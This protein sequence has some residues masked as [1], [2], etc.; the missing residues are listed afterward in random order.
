MIMPSAVNK[1]VTTTDT[2]K[3][4]RILA[5]AKI[6]LY[7]SNVNP[8][9]HKNTLFAITNASSLSDFATT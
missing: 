4:R 2:Y 1:I 6:L 8:S 3:E 5:S 9:G 7:A